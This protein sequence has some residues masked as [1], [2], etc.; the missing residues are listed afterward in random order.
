MN[1][2]DNTTNSINCP[3]LI[4]KSTSR[5]TI[6]RLI[7]SICWLHSKR[8]FCYHNLNIWNLKRHMRVRILKIMLIF[9]QGCDETIN[10][11]ETKFLCHSF[12]N[13][14]MERKSIKT[15]Q[16]HYCGGLSLVSSFHHVDG[17]IGHKLFIKQLVVTASA[18]SN[19]KKMN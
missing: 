13:F 12:L 4:S 6:P 18:V 7:L 5:E 11:Y 9:R 2:E 17:V 1:S 15:E 14:L 19:G 10:V 3:I 8:P 16:T